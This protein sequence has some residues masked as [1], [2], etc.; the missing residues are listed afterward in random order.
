MFNDVFSG[1]AMYFG[2]TEQSGENSAGQQLK[3]AGRTLNY[4]APIY[5]LVNNIV[6]LGR[7]KCA[8]T[9]VINILDFKATDKIL[10]LGCGTGVMTLQIAEH[11][12]SHGEIIGIDAAVNMIKVANKNLKKAA[13]KN[14]CCF[15]ATL[16]EDLPFEDESFDY[17]FSSMFYHHLPLELKKR[18]LKESY[19][20]LKP[21][22]VLV[23]IDIDKPSNVFAKIVALAGYVLLMQK[24]IKENADGLLPDLISQ[25]G[26]TQPKLLK[27]KWSL[28]S[29]YRSIK[30]KTMKV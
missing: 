12:T 24:A 30:P 29:A 7:V 21:S 25:A 13:L 23:V 8:R 19:R 17:C 6:T 18:S 28:I 2:H 1:N 14:T 26:F 9:E 22:G 15:K 20:V 16:A 11:L 5:D 3:T 27:R 10:D 4:A